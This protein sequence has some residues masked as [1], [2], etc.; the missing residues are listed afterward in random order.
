MSPTFWLPNVNLKNIK[1][2]FTCQSGTNT[3]D[4]L[5]PILSQKIE[6][7]IPN[8]KI[9]SVKEELF[10]KNPK[11]KSFDVST[12]FGDLKIASRILSSHPKLEFT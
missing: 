12:H 3:I 11:L 2:I 1:I 5:A 6:Y 8:N 9:I 10:K 7:A 4:C